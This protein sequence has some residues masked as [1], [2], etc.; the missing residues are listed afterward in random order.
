[1]RLSSDVL[2]DADTIAARVGE[3]ARTI[4][5]DTPAGATLTVIAL[6]QGAFVFCADLVRRLEL[7]VRLALLP[8]V[9]VDRGGRPGETRLPADLSLEDAEVLLLDD[10]LDTGETLHALRRRVLAERVARVRIAV[11]LDKPSRRTADVVADYVGFSVP[12][13]WMVGYGLDW[14]GLHRN[15]PYITWVEGSEVGSRGGASIY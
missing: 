2:Y 11:L 3:M 5:A 8:V 9:S 7:P 12:D 4:A 14:Q 1:M 15:L 10:I 13:R 6:M